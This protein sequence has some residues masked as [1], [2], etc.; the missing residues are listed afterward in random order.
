MIR[1][2]SGIVMAIGVIFGILYLPAYALKLVVAGLSALCLF[3]CARMLLPRH[4][5]SS[6]GFAVLLG[7]ALAL[8][9]M[10]SN[11]QFTVLIVALPV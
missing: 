1:V 10:F 2:I 3:E 4:P 11:R 7:T 8:A 6:I 5:S 9:V